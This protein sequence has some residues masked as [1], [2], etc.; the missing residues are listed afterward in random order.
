MIRTYFLTLLAL[1]LFAAPVVLAQ[2]T[3]EPETSL[4]FTITHTPS[5]VRATVKVDTEKDTTTYFWNFRTDVHNGFDFPIRVV[6]FGASAYWNGNWG[7]PTEAS[8]NAT[9]FGEWYT[10]ADSAP[11]GWIQPGETAA[12]ANNWNRSS[13]P[14]SA[15]SRWFYIAEDEQGKRYVSRLEVVLAPFVPESLPWAD[16][17]PGTLIPLMLHWDATGLALPVGSQIRLSRPSNYPYP[18]YA[19]YE[20]TEESTSQPMIRVPGMYLLQVIVPGHETATLPVV[21][22]ES[23]NGLDLVMRSIPLDRPVDPDQL[24]FICDDNHGYL[25]AIHQIKSGA[26]RENKAFIDSYKQYTA[27]HGDSEGFSYDHTPFRSILITHLDPS[28]PL[29]VRQ[30]AAKVLAAISP[31]FAVEQ[32]QVINQLLPADSILLAADPQAAAGAAA[33]VD[34]ILGTKRLAA[35]AEHHPDRFV[36][37]HATAVRAQQAGTQGDEKTLAHCYEALVTEFADMR[38]LD[39]VRRQLDPANKIRVGRTLPEFSAPFLTG[40]GQITHATGAGKYRLLHF[41]ASWCGPCKVEMKHVHEVYEKFH[42]AGLEILSFSLDRKADDARNYQKK[43]WHMPWANAFLAEGTSSPTG[44]ALEVVGIPRLV[45]VDPEGKIL[46]VD[47]QLRGAA[48]A[49]TI[50]KHLAN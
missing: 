32:A 23:D 22:A 47:G 7:T 43:R 44:K 6:E 37:G 28:N 19:V 49:K 4:H 50:A 38:E 14:V 18:L 36:R 30:Y 11:G 27:T 2:A 31:E 5:P 29:P 3:P 39:F 10:A 46:A 35:M 13:F 24:P 9:Q 26:D 34:K 25:A 12:D 15:R 17:L 21:M 20:I 33:R 48:M 8:F 1:A 41:W 16:E 45:L 40:D 42:P